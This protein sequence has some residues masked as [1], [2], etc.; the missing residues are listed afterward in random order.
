MSSETIRAPEP[1]EALANVS[2]ARE[3]GSE[4]DGFRG[5]DRNERVGDLP[6]WFVEE[7]RAGVTSSL[8]TNYPAVDLLEQ[9]LSEATGLPQEQL[10]VTPGTD[11][12]I[13]ATYQAYVRPGDTVLMLDPSY[14][15]YA[16]YSRM[17]GAQARGIGYDDEL[18]LDTARLL[19]ELESGEIRVAFI[20]EPN[21]PTGTTLPEGFLRTLLDTARRSGTLVF[22]DEAY[23]YFARRTALPLVSEFPNLVVARSFSKAGLAGARIGFLAGSEKLV[24]TLYKVRSAAEVSAFGILCGRALLAHPDVATDFAD[25]VEAGAALLSERAEAL[26]LEPLPTAANFLQLR[27]NGRAEPQAVAE[28]L[29]ARGWLVKTGFSTPG[30]QDCVRVTLGAPDVMAEFGDELAAALE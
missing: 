2:R 20:A 12:A 9:E 10:L 23:W 27:M 3:G 21:Q 8:L 13:K 28:R 6:D 1:V 19:E 17:F 30:L 4:R 14:A 18:K 29:R 15:M 25:D 7:I 22:V 5:L 24:S 16:V 26:G 11:P